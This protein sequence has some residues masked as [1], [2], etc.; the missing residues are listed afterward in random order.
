MAIKILCD[1]GSELNN[2]RSLKRHLKS[3][4]HN[5][6]QNVKEYDKM[7]CKLGGKPVVSRKQEIAGTKPVLK[8]ETPKI[9]K[10]APCNFESSN[11]FNFDRHCRT[12]EHHET[13]YMFNEI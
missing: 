11:Y 3:K 1:C 9:F 6:I 5:R 10:C 8:I 13:H 4:K 2:P 12:N 7:G